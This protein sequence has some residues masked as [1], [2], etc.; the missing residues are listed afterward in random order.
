MSVRVIDLDGGGGVQFLWGSDGVQGFGS[1]KAHH[2]SGISVPQTSKAH[3]A[4]V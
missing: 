3:V 2:L 4:A 1:S